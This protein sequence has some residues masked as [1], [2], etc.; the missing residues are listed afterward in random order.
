MAKK[1]SKLEA[2]RELLFLAR[3]TRSYQTHAVRAVKACKTLGLTSDEIVSMMVSLEFA[4]PGDN[5][6]P[7]HPSIKK[8]W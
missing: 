8:V 4:N 6:E 3:Q 5:F 7:Y 2:A 1:V